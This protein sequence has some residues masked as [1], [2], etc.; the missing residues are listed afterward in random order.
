M[1]ATNHALTG[2]I[3]GLTLHQPLL[4][5][6]LAVLSHFVLDASP[7]YE[8]EKLKINSEAFKTMLAFDLSFCVLLALFL[9]VAR[10]E[11]WFLACWCAFAATSPDL[12]WLPHYLRARAG[13]SWHKPTYALARF[14][15]TIQRF[16]SPLGWI[17]EAIWGL[18]CLVVLAKL[19]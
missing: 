7:H 19:V 18:S 9:A 10:P 14:H 3:I 4:A 5:L 17:V 1:T 11:S 2:A 16:T 8:N 15:S 12:M 13:I 6:T